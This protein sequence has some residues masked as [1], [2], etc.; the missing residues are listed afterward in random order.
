VGENGSLQIVTLN[1]IVEMGKPG[2][3]GRGV[4]EL[5]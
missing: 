1:G 2:A 5:D 4:W 3:D